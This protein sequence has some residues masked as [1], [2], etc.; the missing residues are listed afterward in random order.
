MCTP[1]PIEQGGIAI[2]NSDFEITSTPFAKVLPRL[3]ADVSK[4]CSTASPSRRQELRQIE[5][6]RGIPKLDSR[7]II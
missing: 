3:E 4:F 1:F 7:A 5:R 2:L 6:A